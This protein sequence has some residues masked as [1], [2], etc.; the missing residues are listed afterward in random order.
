MESFNVLSS[1]RLSV[2]NCKIF[3]VGSSCVSSEDGTIS[4]KSSKYGDISYEP[5]GTAKDLSGL[6][7]D[8]I[9]PLDLVIL[10]EDTQEALI[11]TTT[12]I[13]S[14]VG[15]QT[16][17]LVESKYCLG[18]EEVIKSTLPK[19]KTLAV[20]CDADVRVVK[21]V[22]GSHYYHKN[23]NVTTVVGSTINPD[24]ATTQLLKGEGEIGQKLNQIT[25]TLKKSEVYPCY[26][27]PKGINPT[28]NSFAWKRIIPFISLEVMSLV[29]PKLTTLDTTQFSTLKGVFTDLVTLGRK[30]GAPDLPDPADA[31]K[32][33]NLLDIMIRDFNQAHPK[34]AIKTANFSDSIDSVSKDPAMDLATCV[35]NFNLGY[36]NNIQ[37]ALKQTLS[38]ATKSNL[39]L[40]YVE[41]LYS[42]YVEIQK[43]KDQNIFDWAN[44][45]S[46]GVSE[47]GGQ[48]YAAVPSAQYPQYPAQA[49]MM[50]GMPPYM[51]QMM[52][53]QQYTGYAM[54]AGPVPGA[55]V[56]SFNGLG[57]S[58]LPI[59]PRFRPDSSGSLSQQ[60]TVSAIKNS[61]Y[62][63][64]STS[65]IQSGE[66]LSKSQKSIIEHAN[67]KN[68]F[69][70]TTSR[71][72][73]VDSF[74]RLN[75]SNGSVASSGSM[76]G[77]ICPSK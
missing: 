24:Q 28:F 38:L 31:S 15:P 12:Q 46:L 67:V 53:A 48:G 56:P 59:H 10:G 11:D 5:S 60:Q 23:H 4:W 7:L 54:V 62:R 52:Y 66:E 39:K 20:L 8:A 41:T 51:P 34:S 37:F 26:L 16:I 33:K 74:T 61:M 68:M 47:S 6:N 21:N 13:R 76:T 27:I 73:D 40:T 63:K 55:G 19:S 1:W 18:L 2:A 45:R 25:E 30:Y 71:Y 14:L 70:N 9:R 42:F 50:P 77:S 72:G 75:A 22:S 69:S 65:T 43:L 49:P 3:V 64:S 17:I 44:R 58:L 29:Y 32:C 57:P 36:A 35:Y